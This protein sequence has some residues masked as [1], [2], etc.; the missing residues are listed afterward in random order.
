[1]NID[2]Q[3]E[4]M[5]RGALVRALA[6]LGTLVITGEDRQSWL[7]GMVTAD[8][9]ALRAGQGGYA[10]A[11]SK[12]GR[13]Q[14]ELWVLID[15]ERILLGVRSDLLEAIEEHLDKYLIMEDAEIARPIEPLG[16]WLAHGPGAEGVVRRAR[17]QGASAGM[18]RIGEIGT[19]VVVAPQNPTFSEALLSAEGAVLATPDGWERIRVERLIPSFGVD[20]DV[21]NYP[22]EA[23]LEHLAVSFNK[24]CY[25]GQEAVF[26]LQKRGHVNKRL[27]RLVLAERV[28]EVE[29]GAAVQLPGGAA[30]GE[31]TSVVHSDDR[32]LCMA[33]VRYKHTMS[34]TM[35]EV[36]GVGA[37]V[38]CL[39]ERDA[40]S[41][42]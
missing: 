9:A 42:S 6:D 30:V 26:M 25:L 19:A 27:V 38:S 10:L 12:N 41:C 8:I 17:E 16:W 36:A 34:G 13:I 28:A 23:T 3:L 29:K 15:A 1:M 35:L 4:A 37:E 5:E 32:T 20:F 24:G 31:V 21:G 39:S 18:A 11:V 40:A 22:Q 14:A 33:M 2:A 7:A